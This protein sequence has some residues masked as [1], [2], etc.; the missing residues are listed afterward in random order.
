MSERNGGTSLPREGGATRLRDVAQ[1]LAGRKVAVLG[2]LVADLY[3]Y[4]RPERVS[5]EAPVLIVAHERD[6]LLP[7]GAGNTLQNLAALGAQAYPLGAIGRDDEGRRLRI[8]LEPLAASLDGIAE[9]SAPTIT[10]MR[11]LAGDTHTKKQQVLR[12]DKGVRAA[13]ADETVARVLGALD[14]IAGELEAV[15][16]SDY[17]YGLANAPPILERL[18]AFA[19]SKPVVVD[20]RFALLEFRRCTIAVPNEEEAG[21]SIGASVE[22]VEDAILVGQ[23][24]HARLDQPALLMTRGS[25]GM[26]LF[27]RGREPIAIPVAGTKD[28]VD[29]TGAGDTVA[30]V[31][32]LALASGASYADAA[33]LSN[34]AASVVVMKRGPQPCS[35]DEL[36]RAIDKAEKAETRRTAK[37]R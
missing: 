20:S 4:G 5:R 15:V 32:T 13:A 1:R 16:V 18:R 24:L 22:A 26:I 7:G 6:E 10:K 33:Y 30:S 31:V 11:V 23:R 8:A 27:E 36:A 34:M 12:I 35:P 25:E 2:D 14:R 28:I 3:V 29:V 9:S 21:S 37:Q 17:G 19:E